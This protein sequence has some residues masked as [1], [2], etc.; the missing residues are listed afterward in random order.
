MNV[1]HRRPCTRT[2]SPLAVAALSTAVFFPAHFLFADI[3]RWDTNAVIPGTT[4]ITPVPNID[5][6]G[7]STTGHVLQYAN[8]P[9]DL[10][11]ATFQG[12]D[13]SNG[14]FKNA[15]LNLVNFNN[16]NVSRANFA[17]TTAGGF[18]ASQFYATAT[19]AGKNLFGMDFSNND[20]TNWSFTSQSLSSVS[21]LNSNLTN[22]DFT[23]ASLNYTNFSGTNLLPAQLA[24][25]A[26][27]ATS[28]N[29]T[30]CKFDNVDLS[31]FSFAGQTISYASF[32]RANL[33]SSDFTNAVILNTILSDTTSHGFTK[34][35]LYSTFSYKNKNLTYVDLTANDLTGWDFSNQNLS[36]AT[37]ANSIL[38]TN[39]T[40]ANFTSANII[41]LNLS[42]TTA[43]G[44][45][46]AQLYST[47]SY[48]VS[49]SLSGVNLSLNDVHGWDFHGL[50]LSFTNYTNS[51]AT[52]ANFSSSSFTNTVFA[53]TDL[54]GA[55]GF[56]PANYTTSSF[57]NNTILPT[58]IIQN[59]LNLLANQRLTIFFD[60]SDIPVVINNSA[61][62]A[63]KGTLTIHGGTTG[64][65][66]S[67]DILNNGVIEFTG[68]GTV[69]LSGRITGSGVVT[70]G[71]FVFV[72]T[73]GIIA[74]SLTVNAAHVFRQQP[75]ATINKGSS[76]LGN[77]IVATNGDGSYA[78]QIDLSNNMLA[79]TYTDDTDKASKIASI[80]SMI[81]SGRDSGAGGPGSWTGHGI[82][83]HIL[84]G[85]FTGG[86]ST[87]TLLIADNADLHLTSLRGIG[88]NDN[89]LLLVVA[90]NGDATFDGKVDSLD[91]TVLAAH[92]QQQSGAAWSGGD[93]T[94]DGKVDSLDL[95]VLAAH[96]QYGIALEA[97]QSFTAALANFPALT[98][99]EPSALALF[100]VATPLLMRR[101]KPRKC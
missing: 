16:A 20:L 28:K 60:T 29:L 3:F 40:G 90:P 76:K 64:S 82:T 23:G 43:G 77:L 31:S 66:T 50:N 88:M 32:I 87:H 69:G 71:A 56:V 10:T 1:P 13:V 30:G 101:R 36:N 75:A 47:A 24:T 49:H 45:T 93:F 12:S 67:P 85:N 4:G 55:T 9:F 58:G 41:N 7:W 44:L 21:L 79:V 84:A 2:L 62:I 96:W 91:L 25:T 42:N 6:S 74:N 89:T 37:L 98:V 8:L 65:V 70:D 27:Y 11:G 97:Q 94:F 80:N 86:T 26:S 95:T 46:E 57:A 14:M 52:N 100:G 34:E 48:A 68:A 18:T 17:N 63:N 59:G 72:T 81:L 5:L 78:G 92:W 35:Q 83:S 38:T 15:T 19:Y 54:R 99:P 22:V 39:G 53:R 73:D 51:N 33:S 61:S